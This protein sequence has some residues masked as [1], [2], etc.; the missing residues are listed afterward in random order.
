MT[1][2]ISDT[3]RGRLVFQLVPW[4]PDTDDNESGLWPT[5]NTKDGTPPR[6]IESLQAMIA[7]KRNRKN[8]PSNLREVILWPTATASCGT[9]AG[10]QGRAGGLNLQTAVKLLPTPTSSMATEADMEQAQYHSSKRPTYQAAKLYPTM[11]RGA[12]KGR[13][14]KSA[15]NRSR[16]GGSLNPLW[17]EALMGYPPGW[18]EIA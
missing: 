10:T 13:G 2:E 3:P 9:G 16:L 4:M 6:S 12:A 14:E 1:W 18:T 7:D 8:K 5:P 17:V 15:E 11:D